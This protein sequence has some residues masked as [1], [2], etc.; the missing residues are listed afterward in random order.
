MSGTYLFTVISQL[1]GRDGTVPCY[2]L[3]DF[4]KH[5]G[6]STYSIYLKFSV[7]CD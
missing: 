4:R 5:F 1:Y 2:L 6:V 3:I 7:W